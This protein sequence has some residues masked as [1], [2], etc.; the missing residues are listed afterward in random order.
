MYFASVFDFL[1]SR[2][3]CQDNVSENLFNLKINE[4]K[5]LLKNKIV[6]KIIN[7]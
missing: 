3:I 6:F 4:L 2:C 5:K 1:L 7:I